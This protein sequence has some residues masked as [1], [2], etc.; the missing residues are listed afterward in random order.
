MQPRRVHLSARES[1]RGCHTCFEGMAVVSKCLIENK[2]SQYSRLDSSAVTSPLGSGLPPHDRGMDSWMDRSVWDWSTLKLYAGQDF[3]KWGRESSEL[4][5]HVQPRSEMLKNWWPRGRASRDHFHS[6]SF[7]PVGI[8][9]V[10]ILARQE[11]G[12]M[13]GY[14][15]EVKKAAHI[16][17]KWLNFAEDVGGGMCS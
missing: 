5:L 11:L 17:E 16:P 6:N 12:G 10:Q 14:P 3:H 9:R 15:L 1:A 2:G 7:K 8:C 13:L 4:H